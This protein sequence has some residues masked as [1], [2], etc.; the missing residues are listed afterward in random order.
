MSKTEP[1]GA[2]RNRVV[3]RFSRLPKWNIG[4]D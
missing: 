2:N 1:S 3:D 4:L